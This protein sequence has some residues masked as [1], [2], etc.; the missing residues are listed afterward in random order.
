MEHLSVALLKCKF[1][2]LL[3]FIRL[4]WN[5]LFGENTLAYFAAASEMKKRSFAKLTPL[6]NV[7]KLLTAV[8]YALFIIS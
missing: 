6:V 8:S 2:A 5:G 7:I 4:G 1:L 3:T